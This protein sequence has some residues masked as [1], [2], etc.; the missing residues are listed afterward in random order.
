MIYVLK[1]HHDDDTDLFILTESQR[2]PEYFGTPYSSDPMGLGCAD[3]CG[4]PT[5]GGCLSSS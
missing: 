3:C 5:Q 2:S 4:S 1:P